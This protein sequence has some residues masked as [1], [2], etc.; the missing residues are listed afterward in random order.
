VLWN[1][2]FWLCFDDGDGAL[3]LGGHSLDFVEVYFGMLMIFIEWYGLFT[4]LLS[5]LI[6]DEV[7]WPRLDREYKDMQPYHSLH[8]NF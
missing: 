2:A 6:Q 5:F 8:H 7:F 1:N 3:S 4:F